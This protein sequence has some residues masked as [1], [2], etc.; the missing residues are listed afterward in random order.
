MVRP[1]LVTKILKKF[2][3][4]DPSLPADEKTLYDFLRKDLE[5]DHNPEFEEIESNLNLK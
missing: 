3:A 5:I 2:L 4:V 1:K